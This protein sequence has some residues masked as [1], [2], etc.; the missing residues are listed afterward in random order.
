MVF[1][2]SFFLGGVCIEFVQVHAW[3]GSEVGWGGMEAHTGMHIWKV[4]GGGGSAE[5]E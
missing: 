5:R 2:F 3:K 1:F 4:A